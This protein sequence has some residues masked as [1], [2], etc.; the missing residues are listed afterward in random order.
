[1]SIMHV[2]EKP[3]PKFG[4]L[5]GI[6]MLAWGFVV[7]LMPA[8]TLSGCCPSLQATGSPSVPAHLPAL[9]QMFHT[10]WCPQCHDTL[11]TVFRCCLCSPECAS[12]CLSLDKFPMC[13][14]G[15]SCLSWFVFLVRLAGCLD[16]DSGTLDAF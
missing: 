11:G 8:G 3:N 12:F 9:V 2:S 16:G 7:L 1:V 10:W 4:I 13:R 5:F 14:D 6:E 15:N